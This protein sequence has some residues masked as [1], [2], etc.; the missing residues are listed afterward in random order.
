M[1]MVPPEYDADGVRRSA[2]AQLQVPGAGTKGKNA[3]NYRKQK[4]MP[5]STQSE[6]KEVQGS[7]RRDYYDESESAV[8][9]N[10]DS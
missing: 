5:M 1:Q 2:E 4:T 9:P 3:A 7:N 8:T 6:D 10:V